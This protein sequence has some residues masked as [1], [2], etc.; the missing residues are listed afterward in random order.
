MG[1][2]RVWL[3]ITT[4]AFIAL[5]SVYINFQRDLLEYL[6]NVNFTIL[7]YLMIIAIL[8]QITTGLILREVASKFNIILNLKEW[9]GL[10]FVTAMGNYVT[11]FSGGMIARA[12]Y[13][14]Y[15]HR[16]PYAQFV[17]VLGA[18]YLVY[19]WVAGIAGAITLMLTLERSQLYWELILFFL[20]VMVI[21]SFFSMLPG[22]KIPGSNWLT[23]SLNNAIDG[24][25]FIKRDPLLLGKLAIYTLANILL[26]GLSFWLAFV[27]LADFS[28]SFGIIFLISLFSSFSI[29]LKI[30]PG[31]LGISEAVI[32]L[33]SGILGVG[34]GLG[35]LA[36]LVIRAVSLILIFTLGPVFSF[37]LARELT[38]HHSRDKSE[39]V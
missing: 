24:W 35:L 37:L 23:V 19:F 1:N 28:L 33:S 18:S 17:S 22:I 26:N 9:L 2:R 31:N 29:L 14:K 3:I 20:A 12:S 13:L 8:F 11:P 25:I 34:A 21:I 39:A 38:A 4:V 32:T 27:A 5:I 7:A 36:A 15:R 16:F 10:P 6:K 30:T